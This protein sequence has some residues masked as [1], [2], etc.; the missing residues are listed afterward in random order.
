M[1]NRRPNRLLVFAAAVCGPHP[2]YRDAVMALRTHRDPRIAKLAN[3]C[4]LES[5]ENRLRPYRAEM[6]RR[7]PPPDCTNPVLLATLQF[8]F[9]SNDPGAIAVF[10]DLLL[11][12]VGKHRPTV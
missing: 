1:A 5:L 3:G 2:T 6:M 8:N 10:Y 4:T 11:H 7:F 12:I 9:S